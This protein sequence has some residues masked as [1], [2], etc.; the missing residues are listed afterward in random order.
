MTTKRG[1][2]TFKTDISALKSFVSRFSA[3][4]IKNRF[5]TLKK[6]NFVPDS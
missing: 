3:D 5:E 6:A 4:Y 1:V 2:A